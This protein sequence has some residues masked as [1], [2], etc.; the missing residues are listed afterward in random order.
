MRDSEFQAYCDR[1][2]Y[3][4]PRDVSLET[5]EGLHTAHTFNVPFENLDV[6]CGRSILL[7]PETLYAKLVLRR[8]GGYCFEMNGWFAL[9]LEH[10][11]FQV[12]SH[13]ARRSLGGGDYYAA[14]HQVLVVT[15]EGTRYLADVGYG[16]EGISAPL[17]I[18]VDTEYMQFVN[19][20]R[21]DWD[22]RFGH[23]LERKT[24]DGW[25]GMYAFPQDPCLPIDIDVVNYYTS[26]NP[27]SFF[28]KGRFCTI[29]TPTGRI[30]LTEDVFKIVENGQLTEREV[31]GEDDFRNL[32]QQYFRLD[33]AQIQ[34]G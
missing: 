21:F 3:V 6:S 12:T 11:G 26:T 25:V 5:L 18:D 22:D 32:A 10:L 15:I 13:L 19:R 20:Y 17:P 4:G 7:D 28:L 8:R 34:Q 16:V 24:D 9:V 31:E 30:T 33:V 29:P 14:L 23:V 1:I 27:A 2:N